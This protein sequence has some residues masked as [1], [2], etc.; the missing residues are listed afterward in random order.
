MRQARLPRP[1]TRW[2]GRRVALAGLGLTAVAA[3]APLLSWVR[4]R[5]RDAPQPR[6]PV[7]APAGPVVIPTVAPKPTPPIPVPMRLE[8]TPGPPLPLPKAMVGIG[9]EEKL[10]ER[11]RQSCARDPGAALVFADKHARTY[12]R[13]PHAEERDLLRIRALVA[14]GQIGDAKLAAREFLGRRPRSPYTGEVI[15]LAGLTARER[16]ARATPRAGSR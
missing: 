3:A 13:S 14:L 8:P 6:V 16:S 9:S 15:A 5:G 7:T 2:L 1:G 4:S 12:P 10:L 11:L